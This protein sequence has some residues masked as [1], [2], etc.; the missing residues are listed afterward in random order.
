VR[1]G[2][3]KYGTAYHSARKVARAR[4]FESEYAEKGVYANV[5]DLTTIPSTVDVEFVDLTSKVEVEEEEEEKEEEEEDDDESHF[6]DSDVD[7]NGDEEEEE[8]N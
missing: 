6:G 8:E 1:E 7:D 2:F 4:R 3:T 5:I